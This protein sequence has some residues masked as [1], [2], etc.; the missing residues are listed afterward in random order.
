MPAS[1]TDTIKMRIK[2]DIF[3][4][5]TGEEEKEDEGPRGAVT[6]GVS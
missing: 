1:E 5:I 2:R 4:A 6:P 3:G